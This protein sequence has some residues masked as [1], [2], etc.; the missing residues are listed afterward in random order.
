MVEP[1]IPKNEAQRLNA[2]KSYHLLDTLAESEYDNITS[3]IASVCDAPICLITLLDEDRNFLK[4]HYG[5]P[6]NESPR[7]T[8]FC[9]H[10][11]LQPEALFI[12]EDARKDSRFVD[13]PIVTK[14][15][16]IFYVGAPLIS[17]EGFPLG[18]LCVFD[19][20]PR[21]LNL[22]EKEIIIAMAKQ[23]VKLFELHK[24]N[25]ELNE[26]RIE[27]EERNIRLKK[28]AGLVT[29]D[30]KSPLGNITTL[31]KM[32]KEECMQGF[33]SEC[34]SYLDYIEESS[35]TM[36]NYVNDMLDFYKS[37][38]L[39]KEK[40]AQ[41]LL[42]DLFEELEDMLFIDESNFNY[43][44]QAVII[45]ANRQALYQILLNLITNALKYNHLENPAVTIS[46]SEDTHFYTFNVVD[47]GPG[48]LKKDQVNIFGMFNTTTN[49][50]KEGKR[51]SGIGLA[52][53][54]NLVKKLNGS[55]SL[56]STVGKGTTITF[57]IKKPV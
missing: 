22:K 48:I 21:K 18:T 11:I 53:V 6:M 5:I 32:L 9:G 2:V 13:N 10:A 8:S 46:F 52:T 17:E 40:A 23:V 12:V 56:D 43:P 15:G 30:L 35:A 1:N 28:F 24:K 25:N 49:T 41:F 50:D 45:K 38:G 42:S 19:V 3:L 33:S 29:H 39:L 4:S 31:T 27:L 26:S 36:K 20:K 34:A 44:K 51:G 16:A 55:I 37:D 54:K 7:K 14:Q 47:N 57:T